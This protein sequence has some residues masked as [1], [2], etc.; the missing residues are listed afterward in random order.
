MAAHKLTA[1]KVSSI[2]RLWQSGETPTDIAAMFNIDRATVYYHCEGL[3]RG[4]PLMRPINVGEVIRLRGEGYTF[5]EIAQRI[6]AD[7]TAIHRALKR[8]MMEVA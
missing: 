4:R 5:P 1:R 6:D 8:H 3:D 2:R 7:R